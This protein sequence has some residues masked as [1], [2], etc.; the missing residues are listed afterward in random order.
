MHGNLLTKL[1]RTVSDSSK[2]RCVNINRYCMLLCN[3]SG[4]K[5]PQSSSESEDSWH[6]MKL[7]NRLNALEKASMSTLCYS[8]GGRSQC[9]LARDMTPAWDTV[10]TTKT[11][12]DLNRIAR[13]EREH[14]S[15]WIYTENCNE[16]T[17][18]SSF[19]GDNPI[20]LNN[21]RWA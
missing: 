6:V 17:M 2:L 10:N 14:G 16:K 19:C 7:S 21:H 5:L 9:L 13:L 12:Q 3:M 8:L 20:L 11:W 18:G 1:H 4:Q 15:K